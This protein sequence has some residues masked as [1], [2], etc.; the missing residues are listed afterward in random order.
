MALFLASGEELNGIAN[1]VAAITDAAKD[2]PKFAQLM[3]DSD[4]DG[5]SSG[6]DSDEEDEQVPIMR[7]P[8]SQR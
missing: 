2:K 1:Q 8:D 5:S 7:T 3:S 4:S 6:S